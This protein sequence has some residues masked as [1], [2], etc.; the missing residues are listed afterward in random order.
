MMYI[1]NW[2]SEA[3]AEARADDREVDDMVEASWP[4]GVLLPD[5]SEERVQRLLE[6][7]WTEEVA[8]VWETCGD[9]DNDEPPKGFWV[10][11]E[12]TIVEH[13]G[14]VQRWMWSEKMVDGDQ[15]LCVTIREVTVI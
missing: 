12:D 6:K 8:D 15:E 4:S 5:L 11:V 9:D 13:E 14:G 10:K 1:A 2:E 7:V 3:N